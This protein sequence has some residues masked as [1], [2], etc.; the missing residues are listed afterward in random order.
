MQVSLDLPRDELIQWVS[1]QLA[2]GVRNVA[3][4]PQEDLEQVKVNLEKL[5]ELKKQI[6]TLSRTISEQSK[7]VCSEK[8]RTIELKHG[9]TRA[10]YRDRRVRY[11]LESVKNKEFE[12]E[13]TH[14]GT[15]IIQLTGKGYQEKVLDPS[16]EAVTELSKESENVWSDVYSEL[17]EISKRREHEE[18][19]ISTSLVGKAGT[20]GFLEKLAKLKASL[21]ED[22][23][24]ER[25][26]VKKQHE[27]RERTEQALRERVAALSAELHTVRDLDRVKQVIDETKL[28]T[29]QK[30]MESQERMVEWQLME[31][32]IKLERDIKS[33]ESAYAPKIERALREIAKVSEVARMEADFADDKQQAIDQCKDEIAGIRRDVKDIETAISEFRTV[34]RKEERMR[35]EQAKVLRE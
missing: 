3:A 22:Y 21:L 15:R 18:A 32:Q 6:V 26:L 8:W 13:T 17:M 34:L 29:A 10:E 35:R 20:D 2:E 23:L 27:Y 30:Q 14:W 11:Q 5:L 28:S 25:F 31:E 24:H 4:P 33:L 19:L 12:D 7:C 1:Q 16:L 9:L